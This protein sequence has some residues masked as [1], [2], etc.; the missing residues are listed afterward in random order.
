M[1]ET[2]EILRD[3]T[4]GLVRADS[5]FYSDKILSHLEEKSVNY[6]I[7]AKAY[8][9]LKGRSQLQDTSSHMTTENFLRITQLNKI[10]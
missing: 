3:H 4:V 9:N 2:F 7:A 10:E 8:P 5:G 6:I 1:D